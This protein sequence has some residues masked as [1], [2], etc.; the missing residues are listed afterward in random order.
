MGTR[1]RLGADSGVGGAQ[2]NR[3]S[4]GPVPSGNSPV[5][6]DS[7]ARHSGLE[8]KAVEQGSGSSTGLAID[9]SDFL[10]GQLLHP[11]NSQR[12]SRSDD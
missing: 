2:R 8:E 1:C 6:I 11:P 4:D 9:E 5:T 3:L 12:V 10:S 7:L